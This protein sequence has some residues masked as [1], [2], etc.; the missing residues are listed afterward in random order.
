MTISLPPFAFG[1]DDHRK[2]AP[3]PGSA[4]D[5]RRGGAPLR[6]GYPLSVAIRVAVGGDSRIVREGLEQLL[7]LSPAIEIVA[8]CSDL[9]SLLEAVAEHQP[10]VVL[11]DIRM[12][13]S[14]SDERI[15]V[16]ARLRE[17]HPE[18]GVVVL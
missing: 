6:G 7:A 15:Q 14:K 5:S 2:P 11:T 4:H 17:S 13:P 3:T 12:P 16:A 8:S 1:G 9:E 10:H 18:I